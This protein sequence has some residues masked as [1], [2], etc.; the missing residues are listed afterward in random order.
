MFSTRKESR[1]REP[2]SGTR[3]PGCRPFP[4]GASSRGTLPA[5]GK[6][7]HLEAVEGGGKAP[8][9]NRGRTLPL[10][11]LFLLSLL[12]L[13]FHMPFSPALA[14]GE[15]AP[16]FR[17]PAQGEVTV[18]FRPPRGPYGSG[19]H[20][21]I[22]IALEP[23]SEVR[24]SSG[25][26][27]SFAGRTPVGPC[28]SLEHGGGFKTTYVSL[29]SVRVRRGDRVEAGQLLGWSDGSADPSSFG[30]H[31]H[32]GLFLRGTAL[33]PLPFLLGRPL[34]PGKSLFLGPW[35]DR[36]AAEA[37]FSRHEDGG[38]G[39]WLGEKARGLLDGVRSALGKCV[40]VVKRGLR[41]A[42]GLVC[43]TAK[44]AVRVAASIYH[45]FLEPWLSPLWE[46]TVEVFRALASNRVV[47]GL[48]AG[49]AAALLVCLAVVG[50]GVVIGLG[51]LTLILACAVGSLAAVGYAVYYSFAAGDSF[52]FSSCLLGALAV[53]AVAAG[54]CLLVTHLAPCIHAGW[55]SIG[56]VGFGKSFLIHGAADTIVYL[57][58][59]AST[60]K[61]I[62][63]LGVLASFLIGGF[64]GGLG[65]L[66]VEG[67]S[68]PW[69]VPALGGAF[70]SSGGT[71]LT[72]GAVQA[73]ACSSAYVYL[74][75]QKAAYLL[76][77]GGIGF[78]GDLVLRAA[79][80]GIPSLAESL[81]SF[82]GGTLAGAIGL[83]SKGEGLAGMVTR[84][85]GG[86]LKMPGELGRALLSKGLSRGLKEGALSLLKRFKGRK[87][88]MTEGWRWMSAGGEG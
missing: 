35:E 49:M 17:W 6:T 87:I 29:L 15:V 41:S 52:N 57:V 72:G 34:D 4:V 16:S 45:R 37:Y 31:L 56:L 42:W 22:D 33:D 8:F 50:I 20:A 18:G 1:L 65:K 36:G 51:S 70:L 40:G 59:S 39:R 60:G 73:L 64:A 25:G 10:L 84:M 19:G 26:T 9:S 68:S 27:V 30:P 76:L 80:G 54:S 74:W 55:T 5:G 58:F 11:M 24:A 71:Y 12:F 44:G 3:G 75:G 14:A 2:A 38:V 86:R 7:R 61:R 82:A 62:T 88:R 77:C 46:K 23:G 81:V 79:T 21:G 32:F 83:L 67:L 47:R 66:V 63:P 48:V 69:L 78:L 13:S 28:V 85:S 53:G 43:G